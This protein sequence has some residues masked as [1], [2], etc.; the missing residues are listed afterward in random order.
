MY[1]SDAGMTPY[2]ILVSGTRNVGD[3]FKKSDSFGTVEVG[4]RA[5]LILVDANPLE[6]ITNVAKLSGVM[7]RG[8]WLSREDIDKRLAVIEQRYKR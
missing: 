8:K 4:K 3:Y 2:Q 5:D 1:P 6:D 7:I